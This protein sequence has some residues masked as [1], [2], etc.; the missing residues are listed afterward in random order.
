M[1]PLRGC[2]VPSRVGSGPVDLLKRRLFCLCLF[3]G[4]FS[5]CNSSSHLRLLPYSFDDHRGRPGRGLETP[6]EYL[7]LRAQCREEKIWE[8]RG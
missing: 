5:S 3:A 8:I 1:P 7:S 4:E 6:R 2:F